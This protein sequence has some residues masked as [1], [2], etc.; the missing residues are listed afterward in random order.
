M[1]TTDNPNDILDTDTLNQ[2]SSYV[3]VK[4][5]QL[6]P[7][8]IAPYITSAEVEQTKTGT[9]GIKI[10]VDLQKIPDGSPAKSA[11]AYEYGSGIH[12]QRGS[13]GK[14]KI[15][16]RNL[17]G[18]LVFPWDK[19]PKTEDNPDQIARF[20]SVMHPGVEAANNGRGYMR[21]ALVQS[22]SYIRE[23]ILKDAS[24]NIKLKVRAIFS[25]PGGQNK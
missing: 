23:T 20:K 16:P 5:Q 4:A 11:R 3:R 22:R 7:R 14:Y 9:Y 13:V 19:L 6:A 25:R 12:A 1:P 17:N 2:I 10:R 21:E 8:M 24:D 15:V 18:L